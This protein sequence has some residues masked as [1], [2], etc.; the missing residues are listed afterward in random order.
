M[1]QQVKDNINNN[2]SSN[3]LV[4]GRSPQTKNENQKIPGSPLRLAIFS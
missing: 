2:N 3:S 1:N 4:F